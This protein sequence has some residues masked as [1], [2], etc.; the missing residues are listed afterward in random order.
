MNHLRIINFKA[1]WDF[2]NHFGKVE[3]FFDDGQHWELPAELSSSDFSAVLS[4][5]QFSNL[6]WHIPSRSIVKGQ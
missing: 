5:L 2:D 4:I 3:L 1:Y 6:S